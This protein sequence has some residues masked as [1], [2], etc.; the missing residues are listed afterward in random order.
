MVPDSD[1]G[2][3][4]DLWCRVRGVSQLRVV[5]ASVMPTVPRA[6]TH[7]TC[8]MIGER[9]AGWMRDRP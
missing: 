1:P 9:V 4:V 3:V 2:A 8:I 7:L 5:D 6:N